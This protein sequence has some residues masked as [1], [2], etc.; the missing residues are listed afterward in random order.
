MAKR[1]QPWAEGALK[2][3]LMAELALFCCEHNAQ[4]V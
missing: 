2:E 4:K 1:C 3:A